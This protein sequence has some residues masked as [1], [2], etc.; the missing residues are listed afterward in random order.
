MYK[1]ANFREA[2]NTRNAAGSV[3]SGPS[4]MSLFD[5]LLVQKKENRGRVWM[6]R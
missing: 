4:A 2:I 5:N 3:G 1:N 6:M